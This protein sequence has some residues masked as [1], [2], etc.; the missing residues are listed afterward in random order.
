MIKR[1]FVRE[2]HSDY[3]MPIKIY[4]YEKGFICGIVSG[5]REYLGKYACLSSF[6]IARIDINKYGLVRFYLRS[7]YPYEYFMFDTK[8]LVKLQDATG[9]LAH[10]ELQGGFRYM[11]RNKEGYT[12]VDMTFRHVFPN[13]MNKINELYA[14]PIK[15]EMRFE[16]SPK[17]LEDFL[18]E[19]SDLPAVKEYQLRRLI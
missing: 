11:N 19:L 3:G 15:A 8:N 10:E 7:D 5:T 13:K 14:T 4:H 2:K 17:L 12:F 6:P 9:F 16:L 1:L 18:A